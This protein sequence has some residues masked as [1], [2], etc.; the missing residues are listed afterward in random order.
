MTY[1][2]YSNTDFYIVVKKIL[3]NKGRRVILNKGDYLCRIGERC[4]TLGM[5]TSGSLKY[6]CPSTN[7]SER[8]ISFAFAGDLV[9]NYSAMRNN[10]LNSLD[11]VALESSIVNELP[12]QL[13]DEVIGQSLRLQ[14]SEALSYRLLKETID[15]CCQTAE[16]RYVALADLIPDIHNRMTNRTIASYLGIAPE[17]LCRLRKRL[18]TT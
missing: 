6:S 1:L 16:E 7:G 14:F 15:I 5:L 3:L 10:A 4:L 17:S 12:V 8:I 11:V 2:D 18:L 9:A 13:V